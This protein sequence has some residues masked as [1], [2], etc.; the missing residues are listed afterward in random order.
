MFRNTK[1]RVIEILDA[2]GGLPEECSWIDYKST[3]DKSSKTIIS[4]FNSSNKNKFMAKIVERVA[5]FLNSINDYQQ[6]KFIIFGIGEDKNKKVKIMEG[7]F[8]NKFPDDNEWQPL[9]TTINPIP[10]I[11]TGTVDYKGLIFG[12]VYINGD[13]YSVPYSH[14]KG[15]KTEIFIR[16]GGNKEFATNDE[17][18]TLTDLRQKQKTKGKIYPKSYIFTLLTILGRYNESCTNDTKLITDCVG[19]IYSVVKNH[20]LTYDNSFNDKEKSLYGLGDSVSIE[21]RNK[22]ERISQFTTDEIE[23]S[24]GI[25]TNILKN[26]AQYS[27]EM[28]R[29]VSETLIYYG[30]IGFRYIA[31]SIVSDAISTESFNE[32]YYTYIADL[33]ADA[34]PQT[35]FRLIKEN[36]KKINYSDNILKSLRVLAW[37]PEYYEEAAK[38]LFELNDESLYELMLSTEFATAALPEQKL[39]LIKYIEG[40]NKEKAFDILDKVT[41]FNPHSPRVLAPNYTYFP[42]PYRKFIEGT[43]KLNNSAL[44]LYYDELLKCAGNNVD[45]ILKLLPTWLRPYPFADITKL[46]NHLE[47]AEPEIKN[48]SDRTKLWHRLCNEPLVFITDVN[49]DKATRNKLISIGERFK[50]E[51]V[52]EQYKLMF[53][54]DYTEKVYFGN[55]NDYEKAHKCVFDKQKSILLDIHKNYGV[56]KMIEFVNS[57]DAV[58]K[59]PYD[60]THMFLDTEFNFSSEDD[61]KIIEAYDKKQEYKDYLRSK[62]FNNLEWIKSIDVSEFESNKKAEIFSVMAE[63]REAITYFEEQLG[64]DKDL[65]WKKK[66]RID[67]DNFEFLKYCFERYLA[68]DDPQK[69]FNLLDNFSNLPCKCKVESKDFDDLYEMVISVSNYPKTII[70]THIFAFIY[71]MLYDGKYNEEK[72]Y[73]LE[74][75]KTNNYNDIERDFTWKRVF[76]PFITFYRLA[77]RPEFFVEYAVKASQMPLSNEIE[78]IIDCDERPNNPDEY[79]NGINCLIKNMTES[80]TNNILKFEGAILFNTMTNDSNDELIIPDVV[81]TLYENNEALFCGFYMKAYFPNGGHGNGTYE[82]DSKDRKNAEKYEKLSEKQMNLGNKKFGEFLHKLS[83]HFIDSVE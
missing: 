17:I 52:F 60:L 53:K 59:I 50:P 69:A 43:R 45:L 7:L 58:E 24:K 71:K 40:R 25:I 19:E 81:A 83:E 51:D 5:A 20:C 31:E 66:N 34:A 4:V 13:N 10:L 27:E 49:M 77:N 70:R 78:I 65:Y 48:N 14:T 73:K 80:V 28:I 62:S 57:V 8:D 63:S 42:N 18:N 39:N 55:G 23:Y 2:I 16:R 21:V 72:L 41:Y 33:I 64:V 15:N 75:I 76:K 29:G 12:Y 54:S 46:I 61:K 32:H 9:F 26:F 68:V 1:Q 74:Q 82:C 3:I 79:H 6:D 38:L 47:K 67:T 56:E 11:E 36:I 35:I 30:N 37:Y 44:Q 22:N